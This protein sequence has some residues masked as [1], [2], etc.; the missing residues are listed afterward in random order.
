[1]FLIEEKQPKLS[2]FMKQVIKNQRVAHAYVFDGKRGTGTEDLATYLA[3]GIFCLEKDKPCGKC[4]NCLR[5]LSGDYA[6]YIVVKPEGMSLKIDQIREVKQLLTLSTMEGKGRVIVLED[7]D[8]MTLSASNSLLKFLEEP[9][10]NVY[11]ILLTQHLDLILPT[12]QSRSQILHFPDLSPK[13]VQKAL[14]SEGIEK[15]EAKWVSVFTRDI[16]SAKALL[17]DTVYK[18]QRESSAYWLQ[19]VLLKEAEGLS[20]I[21]KKWMALS[22]NAEDHSRL[23]DFALVMLN[24]VLRMKRN[25][26]PLY[27]SEKDATWKK[28]KKHLSL[29]A[30]IQLMQLIPKVQGM[31]SHHVSSQ[32]ALD[33]FVLKAWAIL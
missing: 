23:L 22:S 26:K 20:D 18:G 29:D 33:Y 16:E 19:S 27:L 15:T 30:L 9:N 5:V 1:M 32:A 8:T 17:E 7:A 4:E 25:K 24:D 21:Q 12:I 10:E 13:A 31:L 28:L 2:S 6:D 14:T 11:L 3:C